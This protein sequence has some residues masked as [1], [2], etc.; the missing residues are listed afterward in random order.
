MARFYTNPGKADRVVFQLGIDSKTGAEELFSVGK[1]NMQ[2]FYDASADSC[3]LHTIIARVRN[4]EI[5]LLN[6]RPAAYGDFTNVP[7]TMQ[8]ILNTRIDARRMY[9][10]LPLETKNKMD[11]EEFMRDAGSREWL[12]ALGFR[13]DEIA[14]NPEQKEV[15]DNGDA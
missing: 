13:M 5:D 6:A 10:N 2:E 8:D 4:G 12:E 3:D 15:T 14:P 9:D 1:E 11:F 7:M